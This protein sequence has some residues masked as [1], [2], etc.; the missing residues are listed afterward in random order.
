MMKLS[1]AKTGISVAIL[2]PRAARQP[3]ISYAIKTRARLAQFEVVH[4][5]VAQLLACHRWPG[6]AFHFLPVGDEAVHVLAQ[7]GVF[8]FRYGSDEC[9]APRVDAQ[10]G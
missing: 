9:L 5:E 10:P 4:F 6:N 1:T 3:T 7:L 8:A 2:P